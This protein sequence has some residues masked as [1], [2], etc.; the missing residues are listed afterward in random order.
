MT[1]AED[2]HN[3]A[4][5]KDAPIC[6]QPDIIARMTVTLIHDLDTFNKVI[7]SDNYNLVMFSAPWCGPCKKVYPLFEELSSSFSTLGFYKVEIKAGDAGIEK[8]ASVT[9][10][11]TFI[12]YKSGEVVEQVVGANMDKITAF[13]ESIDQTTTKITCD[14]INENQCI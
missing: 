1:S 9:T 14:N 11:P 4:H 5:A 13:V 10:L 7:D 8:L 12:I 6:E 3:L 2:A